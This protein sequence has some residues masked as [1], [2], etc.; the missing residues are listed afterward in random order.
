MLRRQFD[1]RIVTAQHAWL[2]DNPAN[3]VATGKRPV[4]LPLHIFN[5][6]TTYDLKVTGVDGLKIGFGLTNCD[7]MF[8]DLLNTKAIPSYT[9]LNT[10]MSYAGRQWNVLLG[11]GG[12]I[13][14]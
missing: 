2:T 6:W 12:R 7:K 13:C 5:L 4:G 3:L 9:T 14:R 1:S 10:V 11:F 8:G